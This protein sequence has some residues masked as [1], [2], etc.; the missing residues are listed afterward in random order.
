MVPN[1]EA[2]TKLTSQENF[3]T[4]TRT[5]PFSPPDISPRSSAAMLGVDHGRP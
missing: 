5:Y 2:V 4:T 1:F 3:A